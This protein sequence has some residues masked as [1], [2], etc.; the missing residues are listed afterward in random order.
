MTV[1]QLLHKVNSILILLLALSA[2]LVNPASVSA[3][4]LAPISQGLVVA[5]LLNP[6]GSLK[7]SIANG[8]LNLAGWDVSLDPQRGPLFSPKSSGSYHWVPF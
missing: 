8:S 2:F 1:K 7:T 5:D 4:P 6:D 3:A